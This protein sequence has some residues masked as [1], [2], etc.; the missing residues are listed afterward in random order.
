ME[1]EEWRMENGEWRM[2]NGEWR[3]ENG[4]WRMERCRVELDFPS[5]VDHVNLQSRPI[6]EKRGEEI[7]SSGLDLARLE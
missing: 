1:N 6:N 5:R 2:E 4:E 3:M 7:T